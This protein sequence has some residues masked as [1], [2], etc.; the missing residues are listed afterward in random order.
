MP[1]PICWVPGPRRASGEIY[2]LD[3]CVPEAGHFFFLFLSLHLFPLL[4]SPHLLLALLLFAQIELNSSI[5]VLV[6][7]RSFRRLWMLSHLSVLTCKVKA[8]MVPVTCHKGSL[9]E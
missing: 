9:G 3:F 5:Q 7:L 2:L 6:E 8:L 1:K 4:P